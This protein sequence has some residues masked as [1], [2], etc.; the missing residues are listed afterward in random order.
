[1]HLAVLKISIDFC[2]KKY[3]DCLVTGKVFLKATTFIFY[4]VMLS[5]IITVFIVDA[6]IKG[7][8]VYVLE[9]FLITAAIGNK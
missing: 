7:R 2:L 1:M 4:I 5:L 8:G 9:I 3:A 6:E